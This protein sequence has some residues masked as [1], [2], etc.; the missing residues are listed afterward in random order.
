MA[1]RVLTWLVGLATLVGLAFGAGAW[2]QGSSGAFTAAR[3][4]CA[5][6]LV[7]TWTQTETLANQFS[8]YSAQVNT[9]G[10]RP[11]QWEELVADELEV[12]EVCFGSPLIAN[13]SM[14]ACFDAG[15]FAAD[16]S[17]MFS[18][19]KGRALLDSLSKWAFEALGYVWKLPV[20][21]PW[22]WPWRKPLPKIP[23]RCE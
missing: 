14:I 19:S 11:V 7:D 1:I 5:D 3:V 2:W 9:T 4:T 10:V 16:I 21:A 6:S 15:E 8:Q 12:P 13:D 17:W 22:F 18:A 20:P 23:H